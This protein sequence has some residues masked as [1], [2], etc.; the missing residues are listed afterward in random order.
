MTIK[1]NKKGILE[2]RL[3]GFVQLGTLHEDMRVLEGNFKII[4]YHK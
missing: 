3:S 1:K 4:L 2:H